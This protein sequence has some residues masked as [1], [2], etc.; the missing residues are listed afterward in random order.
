MKASQM[1]LLDALA[2]VGPMTRAELQC[3]LG[4]TERRCVD[5]IARLRQRKAA[6]GRPYLCIVGWQRTAGAL[7]AVY[8]P[9]SGADDARRPRNYTRNERDARVR[10]RYSA[11]R[12]AAM[13]TPTLGVWAGLAQ[14]G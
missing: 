2:V 1:Q 8:G 10:R 11:V 13:N 6:D 7:A 5:R 3:Y 14:G 12:Q 9:H 4:I